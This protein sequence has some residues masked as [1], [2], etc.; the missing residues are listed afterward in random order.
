MGPEDNEILALYSN[1][2]LIGK[3]VSIAESNSGIEPIEENY[4]LGIDA[5]KGLDFTGTFDLTL[6]HMNRKKFVSNLIKLG[7]SKKEAKKI[8]WK[9]NK[10]KTSYAYSYILH[11]LTKGDLDSNGN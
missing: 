10:G 11:K 9:T 7:F 6:P 8:A 2:T 4:I 1:G 3:A 5:A